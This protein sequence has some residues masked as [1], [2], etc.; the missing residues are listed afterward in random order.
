MKKTVCIL[1]GGKSTEHEI[2]LISARNV[3]KNIDREKYDPIPIYI[4][5]K[6]G[7]FAVNE[8]DFL[9]GTPATQAW[10]SL[11]LEL[12]DTI[13]GFRVAASQA[14]IQPDVVFPVL[15]GPN[16]EDGSVQGLLKVAGIAFVG[17][18]VLGSSVAMDK[19]IAKKVFEK[20]DI[21]VARYHVVR[22]WEYDQTTNL[23]ILQKLGNPVVVKPANAGSSVGIS[24]AHNVEELDKS[25][26][27]AFRFDTKIIIEEYIEGREIE[28][29]VLGNE[30]PLASVPGEII[31][32]F[33]DYEAKYLSVNKATL[34]APA[35]LDKDV[36]IKVQE[37]AI[38]AF[39]ALECEGMS[40][41]DFFLTKDHLLLNE[42]NTIPGF[43]DISMYPKLFELSGIDNTTLISRLLE[44]AMERLKREDQI[45]TEFKG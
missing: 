30:H 8:A 6:G 39:K 36:V 31:T 23:A 35:E 41:V 7:W 11:T 17:P 34:K 44:L 43:T 16:G 26:Q 19:E 25:I 15:H 14:I 33:Y 29:A 24:K 22:K 4:S 45:Q 42:I 20:N 1:F 38:R 18:G 40:R 2:S 37:L 13:K 12:N 10:Q 21:P 5:R 27:L 32:D 28:C 9:S 3:Y